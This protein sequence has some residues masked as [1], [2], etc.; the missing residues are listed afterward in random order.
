MRVIRP[1][2]A[3]ALALPALAFL[4]R[5][6]AAQA[7]PKFAYINSQLILAQAPGRAEAE[8]QFEREMSTY[9]QQVKRMGDSLNA[10]VAEYNKQEITLSPAAKEAKQKVIQQKE[11]EYQDRTKQ[12]E[13]QAQQRQLE[14]VQP[15]MA[16]IQKI[17]DDIRAENGYTFIFDVGAG[18]PVIVAA[19]KNLDI[20][21]RVIQKVLA[22]SPARAAADSVAAKPKP[23]APLTAPAG[24]TRPKPPT[25]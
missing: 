8:A 6:L 18:T 20:T 1:V 17:L 24:V 15:I 19:D 10:L 9:R 3:L 7:A 22:M 2:I 21:D 5:D 11:A 14:L 4:P 12:L 25:R 13:T 23:G 16:Q